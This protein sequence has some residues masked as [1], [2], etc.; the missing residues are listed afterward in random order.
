MCIAPP[1]HGQAVCS[2]ST[3][4]S[5]RGRCSGSGPRPARRVRAC[6]APRR[7]GLLLFGLDR[8]DGLFEIFQSQV[9]LVGIEL[10]RTP[11]KLHPLQLANQL[12]QSVVLVGEPPVLGP[13]GVA[14]GPGRQHQDPQRGNVV[15]KS[16]GR[17]HARDYPA[18]NGAMRP[19][20]LG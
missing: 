9:E 6:L 13:L 1:Q 19:S 12:A 3:T 17:R 11:T 5:T 4:T 8:G 10:F 18:S 15:G 2:G 14:L 16:V 20:T 7:I